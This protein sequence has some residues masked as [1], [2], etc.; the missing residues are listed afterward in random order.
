MRAKALTSF[1][2]VYS[3]VPGQE[4]DIT[5]KS[6]YEDLL[7]AAYIE[8]VDEK[9]PVKATEEKKNVNKRTHTKKGS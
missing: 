1:A 4:I 8:P 9:K 2:G 3:G 5:D 7:R 6:I